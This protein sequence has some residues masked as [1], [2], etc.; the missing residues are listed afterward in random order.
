MYM[1]K[2]GSL[3]MQTKHCVRKGCATHW[4]R[5][6]FNVRWLPLDCFD[7]MRYWLIYSRSKSS[8]SGACARRQSHSR[9]RPACGRAFGACASWH[10]WGSCKQRE[11]WPFAQSHQHHA[12]WTDWEF[13]AEFWR[14]WWSRTK[15][16]KYIGEIYQRPDTRWANARAN[17]IR[18][19]RILWLNDWSACCRVI[20]VIFSRW[21]IVSGECMEFCNAS[22]TNS[23]DANHFN[24]LPTWL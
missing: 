24:S 10:E 7:A 21:V 19:R 11:M 13:G 20:H 18:N 9:V 4:N 16:T 15:C 6:L 5:V 2:L 22:Q 12:I 17:W 3:Q 8:S 1:Y 14:S 23:L